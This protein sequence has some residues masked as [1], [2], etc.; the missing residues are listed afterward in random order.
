[1]E[2]AHIKQ[3]FLKWYGGGADDL[4]VFASPGRV[5]M[6]GEHTDYNGGFVF[7]A[8]LEMGTTIVCRKR[9]DN[10]LRL[11]ATDL[12]VVVEADISNLG[13]YKDLEWGNY[14]LGVAHEM[15]QAGYTICGL[16]M[17]YDDTVPH[18]GGLSSSAAIEVSTALCFATLSNEANGITAPVDMIE[19]AKIGQRTENNYVGVNCG[20]M[21]QFASAMGKAGHAIF[22]DCKDLSFDYAPLDLQG[23]KVVIANT[24][25]KRSLA[26]S[27]YNERRAECEAG[28]A[29]LQQAMPEKSCLGEIS[30]AEFEAN[31]HLITDA[32]VCKRVEHVI[33]EDDR[34][35]Q[36]V[37]ALKNGDIAKFGALMNASH[38]SLR[39]LYEVTGIELDTLVEEARKLPGTVGSRMTGAGFGGCTVSIV[40]EDAVDRFIDAVGKAY[41]A[42][43]GL[44]A[45][46]YV[47]AIGDG[48]REIL[49]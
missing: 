10:I 16:D 8:A 32:T 9:N 41:Q 22:L 2:L 7:P 20:I 3:E 17:L 29:I 39:D 42:K 18:G 27:K 6:I 5:N 33:C 40:E 21:D 15:Q 45:S 12:D 24:N 35:L 25:K 36:S 49:A 28:L 1:M 44:T 38:D 26:D 11:R 23:K 34:V 19:M 31:R 13:Q 30:R 37:E 43:T 48:G 46:F 4:R 14:Q 47:T